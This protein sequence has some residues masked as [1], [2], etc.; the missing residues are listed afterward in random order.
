MDQFDEK[1]KQKLT[2]APEH[3]PNAGLWAGIVPHL[4]TMQKGKP[5]WLKYALYTAL[6]LALSGFFFWIGVWYGKSDKMNAEL[7]RLAQ[8]VANLENDRSSSIYGITDTLVRRDTIWQVIYP[9]HGMIHSTA[10]ALA[11]PGH[12]GEAQNEYPNRSLYR[13]G[14]SLHPD[15]YFLNQVVQAKYV[16]LLS[17][18]LPSDEDIPYEESDEGQM[19]SGI[20]R[21]ITKTILPKSS[22]R[23]S[24]RLHP[25]HALMA[26]QIIKTERSRRFWKALFPDQMRLGITTGGLNPLLPEAEHGQE[27]L[28]GLQTEFLF[29][30][31]I[32]LETGLRYRYEFYKQEHEIDEAR[33]PVPDGYQDGDRVR[34]IYSTTHHLN[35][36]LLIKYSYA[37]SDRWYPYFK[38]GI[39]IGAPISEKYKYE[40]QRNGMETELFAENKGNPWAINSYLMGLGIEYSPGYRFSFSFDLERRFRLRSGDSSFRINDG[41]GV[42]LGMYYNL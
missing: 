28:V 37:L 31:K 34:E 33:Y 29:F 38:S 10:S 14:I 7:I 17:T 6:F 23:R 19:D 32:S 30:S 25:Y 11:Y 12:S 40:V 26:D 15:P 36:P 5:P 41:L 9:G 21:L 24:I 13:P 42:R 8:S 22:H 2:K 1:I 35:V 39:L 3:R 4:S 20:A 27:W 18:P 16:A